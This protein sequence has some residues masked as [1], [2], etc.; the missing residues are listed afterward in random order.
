[1]SVYGALLEP[2]SA[3]LERFV[4]LFFVLPMGA[5]VLGSRFNFGFSCKMKITKYVEIPSVSSAKMG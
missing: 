1:M 3:L 5:F 4:Y 2:L